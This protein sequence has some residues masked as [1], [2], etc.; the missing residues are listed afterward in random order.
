MVTIFATNKSKNSMIKTINDSK[1]EGFE[2]SLY[3]VLLNLSKRN[4]EKRK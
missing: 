1:L 4:D 2:K 3:N